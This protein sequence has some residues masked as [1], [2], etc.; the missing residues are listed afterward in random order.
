VGERVAAAV[1]DCYYCVMRDGRPTGSSR[2]Y[3]AEPL[4]LFPDGS[5]AH[6]ACEIDAR[7]RGVPGP[8]H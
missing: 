8:T 2:L 6:V 4:V 1:G 7:R 3:A 5:V